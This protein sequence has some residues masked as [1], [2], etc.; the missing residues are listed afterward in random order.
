MIDKIPVGHYE[1]MG[2]SPAEQALTLKVNEIIALCNLLNYRIK[3][4]ENRIVT[5]L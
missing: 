4:I 5:K 2:L 1:G 3:D